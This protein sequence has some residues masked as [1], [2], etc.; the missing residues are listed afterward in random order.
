LRIPYLVDEIEAAKQA[1]LNAN[2]LQTHTSASRMARGVGED[3]AAAKRVP[4][5]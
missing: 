5:L 3:M 2:G 4:R 1:A